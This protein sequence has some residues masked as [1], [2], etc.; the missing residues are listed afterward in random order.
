MGGILPPQMGG[1]FRERVVAISSFGFGRPTVSLTRFKKQ[2]SEPLPR[3]TGA[4]Q[5][6]LG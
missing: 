1:W 2:L 6:A 4:S 5:L 3:W